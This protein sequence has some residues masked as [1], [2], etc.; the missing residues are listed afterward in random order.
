MNDISINK[1][2]IIKLKQYILYVGLYF[3]FMFI[4]SGCSNTSANTVNLA[5]LGNK[6]FIEHNYDESLRV[7]EEAI[8]NGYKSLDIF[9]NSG[10]IYHYEKK[11]LKKAEELYKKGLL[12]YPN[13]EV[14]H[15]A[16]SQ[17]YFATDNFTEAVKEYKLAV[18]LTRSPLRINSNKARELLEQQGKN[19]EEI[20][21]FFLEIVAYNPK[22]SYALY[23]VAEYEKNS[24]KYKQALEKY[25]GI[26]ELNP[27]MRDEI[28]KGMGTCYYK[29]GDYKTA[30][31]YFEEARK[32]GDFVP[33]QLLLE[34]KNKL[35]N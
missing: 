6:Y 16:L 20:Y 13:V 34:I 22:D 31:L 3:C 25:K 4:L 9:Y 1:D 17:L 21:T 28:V 27:N 29:L 7:Y 5:E 18:K 33:E 8:K 14:L 15:S 35:R 10:F 2:Y 30:L 23:E 26:I 32:I 24:G 11:D 12:V 19:N